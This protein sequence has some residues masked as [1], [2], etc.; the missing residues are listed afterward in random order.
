M[1]MAALETVSIDTGGLSADINLSA[2]SHAGMFGSPL[3]VVE[4]GVWVPLSDVIVP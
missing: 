4:N 2:E 1:S 3:Q